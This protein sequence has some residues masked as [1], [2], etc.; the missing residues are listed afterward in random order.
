[1]SEPTDESERSKWKRTD[2]MVV[3]WVINSI[4]KEI[5]ETFVYCS[6]ARTL[7]LDL[8][9]QFGESNGPQI[10][11]IQRQISSM[12]QGGL[13]M[14]M[15]YGKLKK[16]WEGLN[17]LQPIPQCECGAM[18]SCTCTAQ[19]NMLNIISQNKLVQFLMGL[20]DAYDNVRGQIL[21]MDPF[22]LLTK[23]MIWFLELKNKDMSKLI[24]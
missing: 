21:V 14:V 19:G 8:E 20:N 13:S 10:Y 16:L 9:E 24:F 4:A 23:L 17:A 6:S 15:Y 7:W 2:E 12:E 11:E 5:V 3:S 18:E 22:P 1:M